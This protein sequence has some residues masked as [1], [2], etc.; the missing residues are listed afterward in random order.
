MSLLSECIHVDRCFY[1]LTHSLGSV[2]P[3][4]IVG[5]RGVIAAC[6]CPSLKTLSNYPR[7]SRTI[8]WYRS[9]TALHAFHIPW[10]SH[11]L[12]RIYSGKL[13]QGPLFAANSYALGCILCR[14]KPTNSPKP[15]WQTLCPKRPSA[16]LTSEQIVQNKF[17][18]SSSLWLLASDRNWKGSWFWKASRFQLL[19]AGSIIM[20][21][22]VICAKEVENLTQKLLRLNKY[23]WNGFSGR[24]G[25]CHQRQNYANE[26]QGCLQTKLCPFLRNGFFQL[27]QKRP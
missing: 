15:I 11:S 9:Q 22:E 19:S 18:L 24:R 3:H 13:L 20:N 5:G 2:R 6:V 17:P 26:A 16:K 1:C 25:G 4:L 12:H 10:P 7:S 27:G 14:R 23:G 21:Q 8:S